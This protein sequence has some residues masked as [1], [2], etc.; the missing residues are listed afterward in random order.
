[1][2]SIPVH[3]PSYRF[4]MISS[5]VCLSS[6][7][8]LLHNQNHSEP[9]FSLRK[10]SDGAP[11]PEDREPLPSMHSLRLPPT[12]SLRVPDHLNLINDRNLDQRHHLDSEAFRF[13]IRSPTFTPTIFCS[14]PVSTLHNLACIG[15]HGVPMLSDRVGVE[16]W[17]LL[18]R[19]LAVGKLEARSPG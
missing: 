8:Q 13:R 12:P 10:D 2:Y 4:T 7:E 17:R 11:S 18:G 6:S 19:T 16:F 5:P 9:P 3:T 14:S 15:V 1:M